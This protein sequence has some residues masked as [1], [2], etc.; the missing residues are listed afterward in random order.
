M[1]STAIGNS[2]GVPFRNLGGGGGGSI[3][4]PIYPFLGDNLKTSLLLYYKKISVGGA[5]QSAGFASSVTI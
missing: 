4:P 5:N 3:R 2:P 1:G